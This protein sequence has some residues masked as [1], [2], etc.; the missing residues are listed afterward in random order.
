MYL[1]EVEDC[2]KAMC[3]QV[4]VQTVVDARQMNNLVVWAERFDVKVVD[5]SLRG[6]PCSAVL[7]KG[8]S[9]VWMRQRSGIDTDW[10]DPKQTL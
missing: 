7:G 10:G 9:R 2:D 5:S 1:V 4:S 3:V 8:L 6:Q